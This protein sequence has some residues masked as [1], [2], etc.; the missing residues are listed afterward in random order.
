MRASKGSIEGSDIIDALLFLKGIN[1]DKYTLETPIKQRAVDGFV[2]LSEHVDNLFSRIERFKTRHLPIESKELASE[3]IEAT[4]ELGKLYRS[5]LMSLIKSG[6]VQD[7]MNH[8]SSWISPG[9]FGFHNMIKTENKNIYIDFEF[10]G[11][12]DPA[13]TIL[14]FSLQPSSS[15]FG[16]EQVILKAFSSVFTESVQERMQIMEPLIKLKWVCIICGILDPQRA[17]RLIK[18]HGEEA[19]IRSIEK[20]LEEGMKRVDNIDLSV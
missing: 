20:R 12:D 15:I 6:K 19:Y 4:R 17:K 18:S 7:E 1:S 9:D 3:L 16:S 8:D 14:D 13:K 11:W 5:K 10:S 2:R